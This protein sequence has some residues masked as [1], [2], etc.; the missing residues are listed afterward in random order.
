LILGQHWVET[1]DTIIEL[2]VLNNTGAPINRF[3]AP[4]ENFPETKI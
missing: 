1:N 2:R 4:A 3:G